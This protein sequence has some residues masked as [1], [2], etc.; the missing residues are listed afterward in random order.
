[1]LQQLRSIGKFPLHFFSPACRASLLLR[2]YEV[3]RFLGDDGRGAAR[4]NMEGMIHN[5]KVYTS[6]EFFNLLGDVS[7]SGEDRPPNGNKSSG[8][9]PEPTPTLGEEPQD[10]EDGFEQHYEHDDD[11]EHN[12]LMGHTAR[13]LLAGGVAGAGTLVFSIMDL[14]TMLKH[15]TRYF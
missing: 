5:F 14:S 7:L 2:Y 8:F 4:V 1:M 10:K 6:S 11:D 15:F 13:Y 9:N 12:W 3:R